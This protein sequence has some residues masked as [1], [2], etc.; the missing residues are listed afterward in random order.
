MIF[1]LS[2]CRLYVYIALSFGICVFVRFF[3]SSPFWFHILFVRSSRWFGR[4]FRFRVAYTHSVAMLPYFL[5]PSFSISYCA[6]QHISPM[7]LTCRRTIAFGHFRRIVV[8]FNILIYILS[9]IDC[10]FVCICFAYTI[11]IYHYFVMMM[12]MIW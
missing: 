1:F 8:P 2:L 10:T 3:S 7:M 4:S 6:V 12:M 11:D 5:I 9:C